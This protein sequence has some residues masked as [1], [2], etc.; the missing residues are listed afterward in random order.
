MVIMKID[1]NLVSNSFVNEVVTNG[2]NTFSQLDKKIYVLAAICFAFLVAVTVLIYR[3]L[4]ESSEKPREKGGNG[5]GNISNKYQKIQPTE[6]LSSNTKNKEVSDQGASDKPSK[7]NT[8]VPILESQTSHQQ[9]PVTDHSDLLNEQ[10]IDGTIPSSVLEVKVEEEKIEDDEEL[11]SKVIGD[12]ELEMGP[13]TAAPN[14]PNI[15]SQPAEDKPFL[16]TK[17]IFDSIVPEMIDQP[18]VAVIDKEEFTA[19][20]ETDATVDEKGLE[21]E[22]EPLNKETGWKIELLPY[23]ESDEE[24]EFEFPSSMETPSPIMSYFSDGKYPIKLGPRTITDRL[25]GNLELAE[26]GR[27]A[28]HQEKTTKGKKQFT[29][30]IDENNRNPSKISCTEGFSKREIDKPIEGYQKLVGDYLTGT[31][32]CMGKKDLM[33]DNDLAVTITFQNQGK[34]Y[35]AQLFG[36]FDGHKGTPASHFVKENLKNFVETALNMHKEDELTEEMFWSALKKAFIA[37][38]K[39]YDEY[40]K[41]NF[42]PLEGTRSGTKTINVQDGTTVIAALVV[43]N[44]IF[45]AN[46]GDSRTVLCQGETVTQLSEDAKP[47]LGRYRKDIEGKLKGWVQGRRVNDECAV[48]RAIGDNRIVSGVTRKPCILPNPKITNI[49][50]VKGEDHYL[51]LASDGLYNVATTEEVGAAVRSMA[52][53]GYTPENMARTLVYSAIKNG[54]RGNVSVI[55]VK[56]A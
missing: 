43:G 18:E 42:G 49:P 4:E 9:E 38:D 51:V 31:A 44:Q 29:L 2:K 3:R 34:V 39:A 22:S 37:I 12:E 56:L 13:K 35:K 26:I 27:K 46:A 23:D 6:S 14:E 33:R 5:N 25:A 15:H 19:G 28:E 47:H 7:H 16:K 52:V 21:D 45:V 1:F 10:S 17:A 54:S 36:V 53:K 8:V 48:A 32:S 50:L 55:V 30:S 20:E 24:D 11:N 40:W 41:T